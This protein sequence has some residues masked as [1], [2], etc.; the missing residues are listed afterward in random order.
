MFTHHLSFT[1]QALT[2]SITHSVIT[3]TN[4]EYTGHVGFKAV[5]N[6]TQ[7]LAHTEHIVLLEC[8]ISDD[9]VTPAG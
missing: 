5:I 4:I 6:K 1:F 3:L 2:D 9:Y 8:H 7:K